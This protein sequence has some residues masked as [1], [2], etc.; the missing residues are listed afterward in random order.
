VKGGKQK[1]CSGRGVCTDPDTGFCE[2]HEEPT[3]VNDIRLKFG[4]GD[5][6]DCRYTSSDGAA[7]SD[8]AVMPVPL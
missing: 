5:R 4:L 7:R 1:D 2:C 3:C 6:V 8:C